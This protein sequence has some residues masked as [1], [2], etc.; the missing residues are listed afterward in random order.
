MRFAE[1][2]VFENG[3]VDLPPASAFGKRLDAR[4]TAPPHG[5]AGRSDEAGTLDGVGDTDG[6]EQLSA[7]W[8]K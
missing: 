1:Q 8:W 3:E 5:V 4:I 6:I 2:Y 7:A